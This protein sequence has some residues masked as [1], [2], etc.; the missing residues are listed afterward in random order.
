[1]KKII[2]STYKVKLSD[3]KEVEYDAKASLIEVL[4]D[5]RQQIN[6]VELIKRDILAE[7]IL[8]CGEEILLENEDY[9]KIKKSLDSIVGLTRQDV[10]FVKMI[11]NVEDV[12]VVEDKKKEEETK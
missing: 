5:K 7:K 1:M 9:D 3:G 11:N 12:Q 2:V 8:S 6:S 10:E 4:F